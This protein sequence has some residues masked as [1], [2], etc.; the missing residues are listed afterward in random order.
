MGK[1]LR[2]NLDT[3]KITEE[4]LPSEDVLRKYVGG[5]G[6]GLW[7]LIKELPVGVSPL[8]PEN[9]LI[10][11]TGPLTGTIVPSPTNCTITTL[12]ADTGFTAGRSH[13]HGWFGARLKGAGYDGM[14]ITGAAK[15]WVY[16][17]IHDGEVEI[18]DAKKF[19][20]KD[21]HQTED[22]VKEEL[23]FTTQLPGEISVA[24]IGPAGEN[25]CAGALIEND[26]NHSFSHSG[27]G[28][29]MGS[30]KLKAIA[31]KGEKTVQIVD[32]KSL[33]EIARDWTKAAST[34]G[35]YPIVGNAGVPRSNYQGVLN[36]VGL[37]AKNWTTNMLPRFGKGMTEKGKITPTPCFRCPVACSYNVEILEGPRKGYVATL[38]GGGENQEGASSI[39]GIDD[40]P[41]VWY[42]TDLYDRLGFETSTV[43]CSMA[44]AFEAYEKGLL[45][46]EQTDGLELKWGDIKVVET[47]LRKIAKR[48]GFGNLLAD[49]PK[50]AAERVGLP[51]AAVHIKGSGMNLHDWRRAW[52]VLLG[53]IVSGGS[54]WPAPGADCW[55]PEADVGYPVK[56]NPLTHIGKAEEVAKTGKLKYWN[57]CHGTCW[58]A[59]W[60]VPNITRY[61]AGA[62]S[63][64]VGWDFTPEEALTVGHRVLTLERIFNMR[65]GLTAEDDINVSPRITDPAPADAGAAAGKSIKPY[66]EGW[67]RDYYRFMEW[68]PKTGKPLKTTLRKLGLEEYTLFVWG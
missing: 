42:I 33:R 22:L 66:V 64:V 20:E 13:S 65:Q 53:Q 41:D 44:V 32:D 35:L 3:E 49:G 43:G 18:R 58:F 17:W 19:L 40:P 8:E 4:G 45:T 10:F 29:V 61:T 55:T 51:E 5:F 36:L 63:A 11:M 48:E 68:D 24:A 62:V 6:L 52:G 15:K 56:T 57:D 54:G 30:K 7:Y 23:G 25:M 59:T 38:S 34:L 21:T 28:A 37:S 26:K 14:I 50:V 39:V 67:V 12:N 9:P 46:K 60:G 2:I 47:L 31:I 16:L 1:I 27:V